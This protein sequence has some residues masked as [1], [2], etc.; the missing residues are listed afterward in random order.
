MTITLIKE[1]HPESRKVRYSI[2]RDGQF[3]D[4]TLTVN[5]DAARRMYNAAKR[6]NGNTIWEREI[7]ETT[8]P[9]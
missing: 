3:V 6:S 8:E 5:E 9:K 4:G 2:E 1:T 7:V